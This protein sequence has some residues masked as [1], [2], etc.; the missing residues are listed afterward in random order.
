MSS[1]ISIIGKIFLYFCLVVLVAD[2]VTWAFG[3]PFPNTLG[4]IAASL[5]TFLT[6]L[7]QYVLCLVQ[8]LIYAVINIIITLISAIFGTS[9]GSLT[10]PA[11]P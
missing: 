11:C 9:L 8:N 3:S 4:T 1:I 6:S 7:P 2:V 5:V 10:V